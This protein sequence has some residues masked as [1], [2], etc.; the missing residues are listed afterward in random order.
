MTLFVSPGFVVSLCVLGLHAAAVPSAPQTSQCRVLPSNIQADGELRQ[1]IEQLL[2]RSRTLREQCGRIGATPR[3]RVRVVISPRISN[4]ETRARSV[5]RRFDSGL[6]NVEIELPLVNTD[7]IE[8]VAH[9]FEHV[10]EFIDGVD[11]RA[12]ARRRDGHVTERRSDG[13]FESDRAS[14]AGLA[15]AA[16]ALLFGR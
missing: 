9:E 1:A 8:L 3:V 10:I 5:V 4:A 13:A 7:F 6:L 2:G 11:L 15:A 12:L 14:A 16:E